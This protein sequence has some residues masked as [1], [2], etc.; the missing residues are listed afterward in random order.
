MFCEQ[1][2]KEIPENSKFC[3]GCGAKIEPTENILEESMSEPTAAEASYFEEPPRAEPAKPVPPP[4][5][6]VQKAQYNDKNNLVKPLSIGAY[7]G[8]LILLWIPIVNIIML[9]VWSFSDTVNVNK[10]HLAIA[11]LILALI[12]IVLGIIFGVLTAILGAGFYR[13]YF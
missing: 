3:S 10:K 7:V 8:M 1:C 9:L 5:P 6:V 12:G 13:Y 2:G 11:I 4:A